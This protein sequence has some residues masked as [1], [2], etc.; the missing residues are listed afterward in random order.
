MSFLDNL[1]EVEPYVPG[2]QPTEEGI[3]KLNTNECPYPPSPRVE[4]KM[5]LMDGEKYRLYPDYNGEPL[6]S[7]FA[8]YYG[9]DKEQVFVGVGSDDVLATAFLTFFNSDKPVLFP[10]ITYSFYDVWANLYRIPFKTCPLK[11]DFTIDEKDYLVENGGIVIPN[12]NAPTGIGVSADFLE[13]IIKNNQD[14]VVII[15]EAY[16]DF[17]GETV[18]PLIDKYENL[19]VV[20]T[21]SK[22]RAAA[23]IRVGY[24]FGSK[25]LINAMN[26]VKFS[27]NSYTLN[28]PTLALGT[29]IIEDDEYFKE[30]CKKVITDREWT[31]KELEKLG[32]SSLDSQSNFLFATHKDKPAKEIFEYLKTKKIYVRYFNKPRIDNR[33]RITIG[34]REQMQALVDTLKEYLG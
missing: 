31:K 25:T 34:T 5:K 32:F 20:R 13:E 4:K 2:E 28:Y 26:A 14:S 24:A 16:V 11:D 29:E 12:P 18:L 9:V 10:D 8:K 30:L 27:I 22:S 3:I 6:R 23:G 21:Y 33:L 1:R 17:G 19:L 7:A 15:D